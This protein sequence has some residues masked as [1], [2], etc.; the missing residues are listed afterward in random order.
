MA[1]PSASDALAI[2]QDVLD[3]LSEATVALD[4]ER[5][6]T[7]V[8]MPCAWKT[9]RAQTIV[10]TRDELE[11]G[12]ISYGQYLKSNGI[13]QFI[14][15]GSKAE[16]LNEDYIE[17]WHVTH[18]LQNATPIIPP[19]LS[20]SVLHRTDGLWKVV[21]IESRLD[22]P[23]WPLD[24]IKVPSEG[25]HDLPPIPDDVR[26]ESQQPEVLYQAFL[27]R[28]SKA[29]MDDDFAAYCSMLAFPYFSHSDKGFEK[30]SRPED[31]RPFFDM[32]T[33]LIREHGVTRME[34]TSERAEFLFG[35]RLCGYHQTTL[36]DGD[37]PKVG[38]IKSRM[39]LERVG[40]RWFLVS[41]TNALEN[42]SFPYANPKPS[43]ELVSYRSIEMRQNT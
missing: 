8:G 34:R 7:Y 28:L 13:N 32:L 14:R 9:L 21:E 15:L 39:I 4:A 30:L 29:N 24:I 41:V 11:A 42:E 2:Y 3:I 12:I 27:D 37:V 18:H 23:A 6:H 16:Y 31:A 36:F 22:S 20:R 38:P 25:D 43:E 26:R 35:N 40:A 17:G 1:Q 5:L 10:D 33:G 19:Y